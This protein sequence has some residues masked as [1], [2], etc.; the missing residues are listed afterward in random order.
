[1]QHPE[2]QDARN[3]LFKSA[4]AGR[5]LQVVP[6]VPDFFAVALFDG[7]LIQTFKVLTIEKQSILLK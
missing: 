2:F 4:G 5:F 6:E 3:G 7:A 1:V